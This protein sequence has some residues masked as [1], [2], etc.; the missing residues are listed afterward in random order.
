MERCTRSSYSSATFSINDNVRYR[1][2]WKSE[3]STIRYS[4]EKINGGRERER[5]REREKFIGI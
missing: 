3:S 1:G 5:E 2:A 4:I